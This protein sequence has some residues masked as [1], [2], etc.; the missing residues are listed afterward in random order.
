M[1]KLKEIKGSFWLIVWEVFVHGWLACYFGACV[2]GP[3]TRK[4]KMAESVWWSKAAQLMA[5]RSGQEMKG[6]RSFYPHQGHA[7]SD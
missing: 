6:L 5:A 2:S 7:P 3:G 4:H 1:R